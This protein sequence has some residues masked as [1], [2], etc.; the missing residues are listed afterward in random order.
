MMQCRIGDYL[1]GYV[2]VRVVAATNAPSR[3]RWRRV[4]FADL[5]FRLD[6]H[7]GRMP[8]LVEHRED[9]PELAAGILARKT[10]TAGVS[11]RDFV[12]P[13]GQQDG[14]G[15][16]LVIGNLFRLCFAQPAAGNFRATMS[17]ERLGLT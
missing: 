8:V 6:R 5:F 9:I 16:E 15:G 4:A 11:T 13:H 17:Q 12:T 3:P 2:N 10:R 1:V 14:R 7:V